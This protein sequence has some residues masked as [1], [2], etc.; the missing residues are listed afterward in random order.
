MG[1]EYAT[2][3]MWMDALR[4]RVGSINL[5]ASMGLA[6]TEEDIRERDIAERQLSQLEN[7][8]KKQGMA[9]DNTQEYF[10]LSSLTTDEKI[11]LMAGKIIGDPWH[12]EP[13]IMFTLKS[14]LDLQARAERERKLLFVSMLILSLVQLFVLVDIYLI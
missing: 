12:N 13:G 2:V 10:R 1:D 5:L 6:V 4:N 3:E 11:D 7:L 14:M 8:V 9:V